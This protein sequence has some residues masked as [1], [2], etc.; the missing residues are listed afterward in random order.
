MKTLLIFTAVIFVRTYGDGS[1]TDNKEQTGV[2]N[3][4]IDPKTMQPQRRAI[5]DEKQAWEIAST[6]EKANK[7]RNNLNAEIYSAYNG[8]LPFDRQRLIDANQGWRNN[9]PTRFMASIVDR[10]APELEDA[11]HSAPFLTSSRLPDMIPGAKDKTDA[12]RQETTSLLKRWHKFRDFV[13]LLTK[14]NMLIGYAS[15]GWLDDDW[16]PSFFRG[17]EVFFPDGSGQTSHSVPVVAFKKSF[18]VHEFYDL[19]KDREAAE[20]AGY[21]IENCVVAIN[22]ASNTDTFYNAS[23]EKARVYE[24]MAREVNYGLTYKNRAKTVNVYIVVAQ[25]FNGKCSLWM[26]LQ[27]SEDGKL[28]RRV[29]D[30]WDSMQEVICMFT[31]QTGNGKYYGSLGMGRSLVNIHTALERGRNLAGDQMYLSGLVLLKVAGKDLNSVQFRVMHPFVVIGA[32]SADF[33]QTG[34]QFNHEAFVALDAAMQ[35]WAEQISGAYIPRAGSQD[36]SNDRTATEAS[37][38][39]SREQQVKQGM[40]DRWWTQFGAMISVVQQ[41]VYSVE[42]IAEAKRLYAQYQAQQQIENGGFPGAI[43]FLKVKAFEFLRAVGD[44][45]GIFPT[46]ETGIAD[47]EAV[48]AIMRLFDKGLNE[49]EILVLANSPAA[50]VTLDQTATRNQ[51]TVQYLQSQQQNPF[52][53]QRKST[54]IC[55]SLAL[56]QEMADQVLVPDTMQ[57]A[58]DNEAGRQQITENI[59][60]MA[61]HAM[62]VSPRDKHEVHQKVI[63]DQ[64]TPVIANLQPD[65]ATPELLN[66]LKLAV[67]HHSAHTQSR[68]IAGEHK[69]NLKDKIEWA[70]QA[71]QKI[72]QTEAAMMQLAASQGL[73]AASNAPAPLIQG[74]VAPVQATGPGGTL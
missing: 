16:R 8:K 68:Q 24:D 48:Q 22:N 41:K 69:Q 12:F 25:E 66:A 14:E 20:S 62:P 65:T 32:E 55:T 10:V 36:G 35:N 73:P 63:E 3:P 53:D 15:I 59:A 31:I 52:I 18:L 57:Q 56:G 34:I 64:T 38:D 45:I 23:M 74:P 2:N 54:E 70:Q 29:E 1:E 7:T 72:N 11:I 13:S 30:N 67:D 71:G 61:G 50:E 17:D 49:K 21:N 33:A 51:M 28:L 47:A 46:P 58:N 60:F 42:N 40:M 39:A 26:V 19:I 5:T 27:D 44:F 43:T 4:D 37:I 6:L 9:F